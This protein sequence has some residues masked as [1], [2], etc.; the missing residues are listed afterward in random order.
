MQDVIFFLQDVKLF[1]TLLVGAWDSHKINGLN[2]NDCYVLSKNV[3]HWRNKS[4]NLW[5]VFNSYFAIKLT[6]KKVSHSNVVWQV[7]HFLPLTWPFMKCLSDN[8]NA[9]W[10]WPIFL[11]LTQNLI[12]RTGLCLQWN[13][14]SGPKQDWLRPATYNVHCVT[15]I[16]FLPLIKWDT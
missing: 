3:G 9:F 5:N 10:G 14:F 7:Q 15:L 6:T 1:N 12:F 4:E 11:T 13:T 16:N 8:T 2:L